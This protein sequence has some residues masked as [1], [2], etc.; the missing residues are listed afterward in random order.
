[1]RKLLSVVLLLVGAGAMPALA[2]RHVK[3]IASWGAHIGR[4]E[5]GNYYELSYT[6]MLTNRL[7]LRISGLR[8]G[9][10]LGSVAGD[11]AAYQGRILLAPQLFH[12]GELVYVHLLLGAGGQYERTNEH[13][14]GDI[15]QD[16]KKPQRFTYGPQ[17]GAEADLYLGNRFSLVATAT[18]G[19]QFNNSLIDQWPGM[20]SAG[21]RY[22]FR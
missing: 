4:S 16:A 18:K 21:L 14:T 11:Y 20:A 12:F 15:A 6:P 10:K 9:G 5:K 8:E 7:G 3:H 2:Q 22:H 1:M 13:D 19:Y 17:A